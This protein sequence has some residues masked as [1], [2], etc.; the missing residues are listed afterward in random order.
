MNDKGEKKLKDVRGRIEQSCILTYNPDKCYHGYTLFSTYR[1]NHF[2]LIDMEG[3]VVHTW[4]VK[5]AKVGEILPNGHLMYGHMWNGM[6]ETD[7]DSAELWYYPCTQHHDFAVMPNGHVMILCGIEGKDFPQ[8]P[9][10]EK[11]LN[12]KIRESAL[13]GTAYF[14]EVD[15]KTNE[16]VWEWWSDEH[17]D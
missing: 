10:W 2:F 8:R 3:N 16:R 7:W 17:V 9:V 4:R 1:G 5:M 14:I 12:P 11:R 15:P 6:V 13:M